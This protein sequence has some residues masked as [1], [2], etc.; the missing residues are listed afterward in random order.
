MPQITGR[1]CN[2]QYL[3]GGA[4]D[5]MMMPIWCIILKWVFQSTDMCVIIEVQLLK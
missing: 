2:N 3:V 1:A 5:Y 4:N